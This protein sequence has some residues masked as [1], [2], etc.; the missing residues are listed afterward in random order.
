M[1][2]NSLDA[3][4]ALVD[5]IDSETNLLPLRRI[6][7]ILERLDNEGWEI[8]RKP[9]A[10]AVTVNDPVPV[11]APQLAEPTQWPPAGI[12]RLWATDMKPDRGAFMEVE[13]IWEL[14]RADE[15]GVT[16]IDAINENDARLT[17]DNRLNAVKKTF[18]I[19]GATF[20]CLTGDI[21]F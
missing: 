12:S 20:E 9:T 6:V 13:S 2:L 17:W 19:Y 18:H 5:A 4:C 14:S 3:L 11:P 16:F 15:R 10:R 7:S 21:P 8:A 1:S